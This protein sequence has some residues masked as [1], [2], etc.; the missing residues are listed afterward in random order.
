MPRWSSFGQFLDDV[1]AAAPA[2]RQALV[3]ELLREHPVFPWVDGDEA[4]F[5]YH[6]MD[7]DTVALNLDTINADPPFAPMMRIPNTALWYVRRQ[8]QRDDLLDYLLAVNDPMTPLRGETNLVKRVSDH[9]RIDPLNPQRV[10]TPQASVSVLRMPNARPFPDWASFRRVP[11]GKVSEQSIDSEHMGY[12]G[13]RVW[14]YTPFGYDADATYPLLVML[15]GQWATGPLQMPAIA[16]ALI[17]HHQMQPAIIAMIQSSS[18]IERNREYISNDKHYEFL[19]REL[20]PFMQTRHHIGE[21]AIMG[22]AVGAIG[23]A[24]AALINPDTFSALGMISPPLGKGQFQEE[25]SYYYK[26]FASADRLPKRVFQS[27]G[28]FETPARFYKPAH[29]L[30]RVLQSRKNVDYHFIETGSGH[31]LVG[32][33]GIL[34][35]AMAW[36][37]PGDA[38]E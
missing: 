13:R 17:K 6:G 35:E 31:G 33:R 7:A 25:L 11:R 21:V 4:T 1:N 15:D 37:L 14:V 30:Q 8:F 32:F 34:P 26:R 3:E 36:L 2:E 19:I 10:E 28:R 9:W 16:D 27:V 29:D 22:V 5:V 38:D 24:H 18:D 20:V 12:K 23:A